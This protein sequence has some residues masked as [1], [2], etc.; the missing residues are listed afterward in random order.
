[1]GAHSEVIAPAVRACLFIF[2]AGLL[3]VISAF[4]ATSSHRGSVPASRTFYLSYQYSSFA[5][6][7]ALYSSAYRQAESL[8]GIKR[9]TGK[10]RADF[11]DRCKKQNRTQG[12]RGVEASIAG[13]SRVEGSN[14]ARRIAEGNSVERRT[15]GKNGVKRAIV[16]RSNAER[17]TAGGNSIERTIAAGTI[18]HH[19]FIRNLIAEYFTRLSVCVHPK[20]I[21]IIGPNHHARGHS[22]IAVSAL[23]WRTPFGFVEPDTAAIREIENSG[24]ACVEEE[25]FANEHSIGALVPF[26]R[27][28]FP[29]ARIVPIIF[30]KVADRGEC[31]RL[32]GVL[33]GLMDSTIVLASLDF[34]H[35][36]TSSEAERE[37][38]ASLSVLR[39]LSLKRVD[40]A[41]VDSRPALLTLMALCRETGAEHVQVVQHTNSGILSHDTHV[42]CTSYINTCIWR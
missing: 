4:T 22:A 24:L 1:M 8:T 16:E 35:Y 5:D 15:V 10:I 7:T 12:G 20:R 39:S 28:S 17:R 14:A 30:K 29:E 25:P 11:A 3:F 6:D 36:R 40:E 42:P 27:R 2:L 13:W 26:I 32:A 33:S 23:R 31:L 9:E 21:I 19:L 34:S 37:D 18:S 38:S 41:F